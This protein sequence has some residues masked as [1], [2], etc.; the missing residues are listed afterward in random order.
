MRRPLPLA[1]AVCALAVAAVAPSAHAQ[2]VRQPGLSTPLGN[3]LLSN[4]STLT[5]W[6][7]ARVTAGVRR[8][9]N[10]DARAFTRLHRYTEDG[11]PEVY[12]VLRSYVDATGLTWLKIRVPMRPN[13][14]RGWVPMNVLGPLQIVATHLVINRHTLRATLTRSGHVIWRSPVGVGKSSTPTP[15]GSFYIRERLRVSQSG[16]LYGPWAFGTSD[17]SVLTDWPGGGVV[18]IHG[19]N[20]PQLIPGRPSHGC[21]RIPNAAISRLAHLM[22]VGTPIRIL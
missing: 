14:R 22:P 10:L 20:E 2:S 1:V 7:H 6:A 16:S 19:T 11:L 13:G 8:E 3:E 5:R 21:V 4:E 12:V 18:G 17:Y 9:P 15:A